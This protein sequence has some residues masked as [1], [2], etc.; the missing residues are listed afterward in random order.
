M[1]YYYLFAV[2]LH[3]LSKLLFSG[4][5]QFEVDF[6]RGENSLKA[7]LRPREELHTSTKRNY[8]NHFKKIF[9]VQ[10]FKFF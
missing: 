4:F 6:V 7:P 2:F 9:A 5:P 10:L 3:D 8:S 1:A